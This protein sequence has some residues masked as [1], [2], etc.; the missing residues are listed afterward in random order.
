MAKIYIKKGTMKESFLGVLKVVFLSFLVL[1][2]RSKTDYSLPGIKGLKVIVFVYTIG[3]CVSFFHFLS[4]VVLIPV[5]KAGYS[6]PVILVL[7][8]LHGACSLCWTL[9]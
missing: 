3:S 8:S 4:F 2:P 5:S 1:I 6:L 7:V 9:T